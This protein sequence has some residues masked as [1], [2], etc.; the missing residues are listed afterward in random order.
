MDNYQ[1]GLL[2]WKQWTDM[3]NGQPELARALVA[4]EFVLHL[5]G[6]SLV[7]EATV[8]DPESV[9][10]FVA[11]HRARHDKLEFRYDA[12]PFV[13]TVAGVVAGPWSAER[14]IDGVPS[15]VCGMDTIRFRDGKITEYWTLAKEADAI[16]RWCSALAE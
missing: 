1:T 5:A 14:V 8:S 16:G 11:G 15:V 4:P 13:D 7:D 6:T 10:R 2:L 9:V 12:G 3:W